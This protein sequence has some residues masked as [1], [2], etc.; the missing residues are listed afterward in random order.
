VPGAAGADGATG[1]QGPSGPAGPQGLT[2]RGTWNAGFIYVPNDSVAFGG[3]TYIAL[4]ANGGVEPD[5]D[6]ATSGGHW[7][8]LAQRGAS[9]AFQSVHSLPN[10]NPT[11]GPSIF[12]SPVGSLVDDAGEVGRDVAIAPV[13]CT[14]T[15][16]TIR[17]DTAVSPGDSAIYTLRVG[18][19]LT[20]E[21]TNDMADTALSCSMT[22]GTQF[23]T[24]ASP[25][26]ALNANALFDVSVTVNGDPLPS[27]S[28]VVVAL[29]CQ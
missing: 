6:V 3:S 27:P 23:C 2:F 29:V 4:V 28:N 25:P 12:L 20:F 1:S 9:A 7:A 18:T 11:E 26:I 17:S 10:L 5:T 21:G 19:N 22:A 13:A 24:A 15:S 16:I 8:L 14:M